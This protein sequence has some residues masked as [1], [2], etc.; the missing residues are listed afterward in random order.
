MEEAPPWLAHRLTQEELIQELHANI[1]QIRPFPFPTVHPRRRRQN[2]AP[3]SLA[4]FHPASGGSLPSLHSPP[5]LAG[6]WC[7]RCQFDPLQTHPK[8]FVIHLAVSY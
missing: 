3:I 2:T 5:S 1:T 6:R 4:H 8:V 7:V